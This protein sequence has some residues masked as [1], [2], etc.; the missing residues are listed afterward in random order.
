MSN[1]WNQTHRL[2]RFVV[3]PIATLEYYGWWNKR[4]ND[5]IPRLS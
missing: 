3:G 5:N 4:V 1:A 2:K